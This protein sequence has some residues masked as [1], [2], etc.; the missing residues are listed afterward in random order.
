MKYTYREGIK[1]PKGWQWTVIPLIAVIVVAYAA[2][3][4]FAPVI[5]YVKGPADKTANLLLSTRP[6][7]AENILYIPKINVT[8]GILP[9]QASEALSL[10]NGAVQR[11]T[12]SGNP[13]DGGTYVLTAQRLNLEVFPERTY[14]TSPFYHLPKLA[15]NDDIYIDY[16]GERYAYKV[17]SHSPVNTNDTT[18]ESR[19]DKVQLVL[20]PTQ[21][22]GGDAEREVVKAKLV[23]RIIW[24]NEKPR[25]KAY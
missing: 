8:V 15:V 19:N 1:K 5:Y 23:G 21:V 17:L 12:D 7:K 20:Y 25:L 22:S 4:Y 9:V 3:N 2:V 6:D 13:E 18:I 14:A 11:A 16:K 10:E 24:V